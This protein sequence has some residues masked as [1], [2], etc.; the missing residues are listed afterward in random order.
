[1]NEAIRKNQ[2]IDNARADIFEAIDELRDLDDWGSLQA[3]I[4]DLSGLERKVVKIF[5]NMK[6]GLLNEN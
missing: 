1:M 2:V 3:S 6:N 4:P 5:K